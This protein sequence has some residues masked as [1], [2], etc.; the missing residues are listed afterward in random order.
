MIVL[1]LCDGISTGQQ[2]LKEL[3]I[4]VDTYLSSEID[5]NAILV[6]QSHFPNTIQIG[7]MH[8]I[9]YKDGILYTENGDF[10]IP[11]IDLVLSGTPCVSFSV[12]GK[13]EKMKGVSGK[14]F[15][16]F[17]RILNEVKPT[18]FLFENVKMS[19]DVASEISNILGVNY[20][21]LNSCD[22]S[23]QV[24]K[25]YYWTNIVN[26]LDCVENKPKSDKCIADILENIIFD[27]DCSDI[28]INAPYYPV[29][30]KDNII[31]INTRGTKMRKK[32]PNVLMQ[33]CQRL[34][35]Y[36]VKGKSPALCATLFDMKITKDH[37]K[38]RKLTI[39]ECE[40]LQGLPDGYTSLLSRSKAG[41]ALGN[42]WQLDTVK[43]IL[44]FLK[45]E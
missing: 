43:Y 27:I 26:E 39:T 14:L 2:A 24:R 21:Y 13:K 23:A 19:S 9:K 28:F 6:A 5:E 16:E 45:K 11:H 42:A 33:S 1:S 35:I 22:F 7:D 34:R 20:I 37:K 30:G 17:S 44:S 8:N 31:C 32:Q 3:G 15:Y 4:K 10:N 29:V 41:F 18:Y 12:A 38:Y 36:D 40:R 25:R